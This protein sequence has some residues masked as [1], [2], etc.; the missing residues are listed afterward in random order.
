MTYP[1]AR[2]MLPLS[3]GFDRLLST[4]QDFEQLDKKPSS[5]PPYNIVKFDSDN[6]QIQI[7]VAGFDKQDIKIDYE[8]CN[9]YVNGSIQMDS[10]EIEYIHHGLASRDFSHK[11]KLTDTIV[12]K[13]ADIVNGVLQIDLQNILPESK[14][15]RTIPIGSED[16]IL[17][18]DK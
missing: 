8:N 6:Y 4:L 15:A 2:N 3:V 14:K 9:L 17:S 18:K 10:T 16:S 1:Y 13:G 12:V 11:F 7:A 5:Y